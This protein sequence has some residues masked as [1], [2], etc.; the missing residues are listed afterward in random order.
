MEQQILK[1]FDINTDAVAT[2]RGF[3]FQYLTVLKKWVQNFINEKDIETYTEVDNDIK[4]VGEDLI[5]TQVKCYASN[6][7]FC[8]SE[9]KDSI[10]N[11]F[12]LFLKYNNLNEN[13]KFCFSTNTRIAPRE[14]LLARW[15]DDLQLNDSQLQV[16]CA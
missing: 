8:S 16:L 14:K 9:I 10:F 4:E 15:F 12:L 1:I 3:Y 5:F 6:F 2:N 11:F 7:S 13:I